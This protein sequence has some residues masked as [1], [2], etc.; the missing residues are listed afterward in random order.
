MQRG[1][2]ANPSFKIPLRDLSYGPQPCWT[3]GG[4]VVNEG[5]VYGRKGVLDRG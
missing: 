3:G 4:S 5:A 2:I 1:M